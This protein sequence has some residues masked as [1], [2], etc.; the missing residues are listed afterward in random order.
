M[1]DREIAR[2]VIHNG[3]E[4]RR[5]IYHLYK[6]FALVLVVSLGALTFNSCA[7]INHWI[8]DEISPHSDDSTWCDYDCDGVMWWM[9][10]EECDHKDCDD[11]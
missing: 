1:P 3:D 9:S 4:F 10:C 11:C 8:D 5:K 2:T 6:A 7:V